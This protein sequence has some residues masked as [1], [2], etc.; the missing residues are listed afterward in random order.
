[1]MNRPFSIIVA[2][3]PDNNNGI[4]YKGKLPWKIPADMAY[5]R[6]ITTETIDPTKHNAVIMGRK[7]WESIPLKHR[8]LP[9]RLNVVLTRND[10][11]I[12]PPDV[13]QSYSLGHALCVLERLHDIESV[14]IIGGEEVYKE[15][16]DH[17]RCEKIYM[18]YVSADSPVVCDTYFPKFDISKYDKMTDSKITDN[19]YTCRFVGYQKKT[20]PQLPE[21]PTE[22][23]QPPQKNEPKYKNIEEQQYLDLARDIMDHGNCRGDRTGTGTMS[24]FGMNMRF[25]LRDGNFPLLTT[26]KV[27]FKGVAEELL[28]FISGN[29]NAKVLRDKGVTI[30]DDN[31]SRTYLDSVGL[32]DR[33]ED[34]LGPCFIAGT[35]VA[36]FNGYKKIEDIT[37]NDTVYSHLGNWKSIK[38]IQQRQ[39]TGDLVNLSI[40]YHPK[41][42]ISTPEHPYYAREF[43][44]KDRYKGGRNV[45]I[46]EDPKWVTASTLTK[47]HLVGFPIETEETVPTINGVLLEDPSMWFMMGYFLG[48]GWIQEPDNHRILFAV[49]DKQQSNIV[50][51]ISTILDIKF[52]E[53]EDDVKCTK[54][55]C[56]NKIWCNILSEFGKYAYGK[57]IPQWIHKAPKNL[58]RQFLDGYCSAN[59][60]IRK[61]N[62][63]ESRRYTT[64]SKDIAYSVQRLYLKI[65][66]FAS[67]HFQKR[68]YLKKWSIENPKLVYCCDC[69]II[70]VYENGK[71]RNNYSFIENNYAW[72]AIKDIEVTQQ[73]NIN[74]Y[75]FEVQ[76]DN[77]YSVENLSVHNC[78]GWQWRHFGAKYTNM[79]ADYTGQGIDQLANIIH[80]IKTNPTDR[81]IILSAWNPTDLKL[82]AL[83][84]CFLPGT[85]TLTERGYIPIEEVKDDDKLMS[86]TGIF[87]KIRERHITP[88]NGEVKKIKT[89]YHS[90][91][92]ISTPEH[93]FYVKISKE[94]EPSWVEASKL[95]TEMFIGMP[96]NQDNIIPSFAF[97]QCTNQYQ[98]TKTTMVLD[99]P[100]HWFICGYFVGDGWIDWKKYRFNFAIAETDIEKIL[101][102]IS[103]HLKLEKKN[104]EHLKN[105]TNC[106]V[107]ECR[108]MDWWNILKDFGHLPHNKKI[109]EWVFSAPKY[110]I[111]KFIEGYI[112]ADG[113]K[114]RSEKLIYATT[115]SPH[116][117]FGFQ[118]LYAKLG[119]IIAIRYQHKSLIH[120]IQ[121]RTVNQRNLYHI[122]KNINTKICMKSFI[123]DNYMWLKINDIQTDYVKDTY[124]YNFDVKDEPSY[125]VENFAVHNCHMFCQFYVTN[126]ELSCQMYQR[127]GDVGLGVPFN[128]AS[129]ALLTCIIAHVCGLKP[130]E[131]IHVI[132][133]THV[134]VS[135]IEPLKEQLKRTP[136][137]FPKLKINTANKDINGFK[138]SDFEL[139]DYDPYPKI[140]MK[141]SV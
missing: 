62:T 20:N 24:K 27:F 109:P 99:N 1:M 10:L 63:N 80:T 67:I 55:R 4:G 128:I 61:T 133:D 42:I 51:K 39:Y 38:N 97:E 29:T 49:S 46:A 3:T 139:I 130:G 8:P 119:K 137:P 76:D 111:E 108:N 43:K 129:Y 81:R 37:I 115:V 85:L 53:K 72:F 93:P 123:Q 13:L 140:K 88:Y 33:E 131:F 31:A 71:R 118:R 19:G 32:K 73:S 96:I 126:G 66:M 15:A 58:I 9:N 127:S 7:T 64:I 54:Y 11:N 79:H 83:P 124:V 100:E 95:T 70:E 41:L 120:I 117:A 105:T 86:H 45:V 136:R 68:D 30:W 82:M 2:L 78:Y 50:A 75:N 48:D 56:G 5:F 16:I 14:F 60:C 77:S 94:R 26:K 134:Y 98:A 113:C 12:T 40:K 65:G 138:F 59:G 107:Y 112:S 114:T 69:Y 141:I 91:E 90:K 135:H 25:N 104:P 36:T 28:W 106:Y 52:M 122:D 116:L 44:T 21:F 89:E 103:K 57:K 110:L 102:L 6:S 23:S 101:P 121:S 125:I 35:N 17:P 22:P 18:T 74:V 47:K 92:I 34:D 132:G 84:P 87:R